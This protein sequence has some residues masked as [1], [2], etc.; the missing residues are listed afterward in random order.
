LLENLSEQIRLCYEH[1]AKARERAEAS[2][3]PAVKA[4][5]VKTERRWLLLARSYELAE[6]LDDFTRTSPKPTVTP[7]FDPSSILQ[8]SGAAVFAKDKDGR[9]VFANPTFMNLVGRSWSELCGRSDAEW[10]SDGVEARNILEHDRFV[11]ES[12]ETHVFEEPLP[13]TQFG[14]RIVLSTKAPLRNS[15]GQIVGMIG[16]ANDI[17]DRKNREQRAELLQGELHHRLKNVLSLVQAMAHASI[18][19]CDGLTRFEDRLLAYARSQDLIRD[20]GESATLHQLIA[21][22]QAAFPLGDKLHVTGPDLSLPAG[23]VIEIGMALH[24]LFANSV[25]YGALSGA[26]RIDID[27][28]AEDQ[29]EHKFLV[30]RWNEHHTRL[31]VEPFREGFGHGVLTRAVP[32][33]LN[34]VAH[35][36]IV[37]G[38]VRWTLRAAL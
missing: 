11:V 8:A 32:M 37:P 20:N 2:L 12:G 14:S 26:G 4:D 29:D 25:K 36:E 16:V 13:T 18:E 27:W 38:E 24:E 23:F 7:P 30:V 28:Y 17:T 5:F 35:F 1:A 9:M 15:D 33:N 22:Y 31:Q 10:H 3:D 21:S 34:G 19:P 6:R